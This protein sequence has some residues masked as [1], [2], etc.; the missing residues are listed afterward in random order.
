M[1]PDSHFDFRQPALRSSVLAASGQDVRRCKNCWLCDEV[2]IGDQDITLGMLV[3]LTVLNDDEVLTS[4]TLWS[5]EVLQ[6]A[7]RACTNDLN[8]SAVMLALRAEARRRNQSNTEMDH[9]ENSD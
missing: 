1:I 7:Q 3:Q 9:H 5:D 4:R 8:L 6:A 2:T